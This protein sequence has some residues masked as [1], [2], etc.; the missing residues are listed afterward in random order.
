MNIIGNSFIFN[1]LDPISLCQ[2]KCSVKRDNITIYILS[3]DTNW[4]YCNDWNRKSFVFSIFLSRLP[5]YFSHSSYNA[6][7]NS[8]C[9]Y[10]GCFKVPLICHSIRCWLKNFQLRVMFLCIYFIY[11]AVQI[12]LFSCKILFY[13]SLNTFVFIKRIINLQVRKKLYLFDKSNIT[14]C[15]N[16]RYC[17]PIVYKK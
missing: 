16:M 3:F 2:N 14:L 6:S 12:F 1:I 7:R 11:L 5:A 15:S 13:A 9:H 4:K 17:H 8:G 10:Y